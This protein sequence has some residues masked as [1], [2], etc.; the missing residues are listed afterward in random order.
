IHNNYEGLVGHCVN[1]LPIYCKIDDQMSFIEHFE[2]RKKKLIEVYSNQSITL[3]ALIKEMNLKRDSHS[4]GPVSVVFN[5][6]IGLENT[7]V[8]NGGKT[9]SF[10]FDSQK[11]KLDLTLNIYG[12]EQSPLFE[13]NY[14]TNIFRKQSIKTIVQNFEQLTAN[15]LSDT[16]RKLACL[17][18]KKK[19]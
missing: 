10:N 14:N 12:H 11:E 17:S 18:G 15:L 7:L 8:L 19:N 6:I 5:S 16:S 9:T 3:G 13:W 2:Q 1:L 4:S